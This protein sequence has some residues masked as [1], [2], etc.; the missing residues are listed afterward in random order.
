MAHGP[1]RYIGQ[2][3]AISVHGELCTL[4]EVMQSLPCC[5]RFRKLTLAMILLDFFM[6]GVLDAIQIIYASNI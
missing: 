4:P 2:S 3:N 5:S 1:T 6:Y